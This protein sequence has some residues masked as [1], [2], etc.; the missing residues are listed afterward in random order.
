L[1]VFEVRGDG[2]VGPR[3]GLI[4]IGMVVLVTAGIAAVGFGLAVVMWLL[5]T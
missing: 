2:G 1:L 5:A 3:S 4:G